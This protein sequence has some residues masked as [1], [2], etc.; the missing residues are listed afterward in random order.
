M[1][2]DKSLID[3]KGRLVIIVFIPSKRSRYGLKAHMLC[4]SK[5]IYVHDWSLHISKETIEE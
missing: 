2:I 1:S 3:W 5:T 4:E